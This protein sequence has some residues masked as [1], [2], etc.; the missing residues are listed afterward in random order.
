[1]QMQHVL[2]PSWA[3]TDEYIV[4]NIPN[5]IY[6]P[7]GLAQAITNAYNTYFPAIPPSIFEMTV[8]WDSTTQRFTFYKTPIGSGDSGNFQFLYSYNPITT[9]TQLIGSLPFSISGN[10][11]S[12]LTAP[13][14][15]PSLI[16]PDGQP[17]VDKGELNVI[18][19]VYPK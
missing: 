4:L 5:G 17:I 1:M 9:I 3:G 14:S 6:N 12:T 11:Q 15:P 2:I 7:D 13:T 18:L 16:I 10:P 8:S 19:K